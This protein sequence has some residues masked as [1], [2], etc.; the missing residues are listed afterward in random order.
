MQLNTPIYYKN[1]GRAQYVGFN[2]EFRE[3][4]I[5]DMRFFQIRTVPEWDISREIWVRITKDEFQ[6]RLEFFMKVH[7]LKSLAFPNSQWNDENKL[8]HLK[9]TL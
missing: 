7:Y 3:W 8:S 4:T 6:S 9:L 2:P 1:P 5:L